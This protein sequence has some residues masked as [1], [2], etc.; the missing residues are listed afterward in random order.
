[1]IRYVPRRHPAKAPLMD[2]WLTITLVGIGATFFWIAGLYGMARLGPWRFLAAKYPAIEFPSGK[3]F[4][5]V[6]LQSGVFSY[7]NCFVAVASSEYLTLRAIPPFQLFHP[8]ITLPR[9]SVT[10]VRT[11][12]G[13][14]IFK[15]VCFSLSGRDFTIYGP[16]VESEFWRSKDESKVGMD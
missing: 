3:R 9:A 8:A 11:F 10:G 4:W 2:H 14:W 13:F 7:S 15:S 12:N 5:F 1:M 16:V 6:S